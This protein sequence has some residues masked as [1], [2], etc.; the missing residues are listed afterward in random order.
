MR[1]QWIA[2]AIALA[3]CLLCFKFW[4]LQIVE[5]HEYA[6]LARDN[7]VWEKRLPSDRGMIYG[8]DG[9]VMADNRASADIVFVP[10]ECTEE[11]LPGVIEKISKL[12]NVP[13][14]AI[15]SR[16]EAA[17]GAPFS[18]VFIKRDVTRAD[19]IRVEEHSAALPGVL[20]VV[21][22]QRR[23]LHG[24]VGGQ[25]LGFLGQI[26]Q[27]ELESLK[28]EDYGQG[29]IVGKGGIERVYETDLRGHD[30]Y[31]VVTKYATGRPQLET[32]RRG[33][34][35]VSSRDSE[36]HLLR[37]EGARQSP[38]PGEPIYLTLDVDLQRHCEETLNGQVGSIV[39]LNADTGAIYAL[40]SNPSF[41]PNV[42]VTRDP[43]CENPETLDNCA[44]LALLKAPEPNP[45][46]SRAYREN[47]PPGSVYKVLLAAAALEEGV[48]DEHTS[49]YCPGHFQLGAG[50]HRWH[51]WRRTGHGTVAVR[52]ALAFSCDVFFYNVGLKLG[53][54]RIVSWSNKL[55]L[56]VKTGIDL[57]GEITGLIPS[58]D[59]KAKLFEGKAPSEKKW[60]DG[61]TVNLSIGQGSASATPL[62]NAVMMASI[63]NG[64]KR[65]RPYLNEALGPEISEPL[66]SDGHIQIIEE[67]MRMC[68][69]KK[70]PPPTG[71][72]KEAAVDGIVVIGKTG[73]AQIM[74]LKHHEKF[75]TEEDIPYEFRDHA[76]FVAGVLDQEPRIAMCILVE[77]GHHGS[78][79][80]APLA[81][82]V[83]EYFY[84]GV[85]SNPATPQVVAQAP[86]PPATEA[87]VKPLP[88][89]DDVAA[90]ETEMEL[91]P[92]ATPE[93]ET[94][95]APRAP[96]ATD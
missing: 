9:V 52:E 75:A 76:W 28:L 45:M 72:G 64:G 65:V 33:I 81:K 14:E 94:E 36:G 22:P 95:P 3:M 89:P 54:N 55:G 30:G 31:A 77:H 53:V 86:A 38:V 43:N 82:G 59:W 93:P 29:D 96:L 80:A 44:R 17:K 15:H 85:T 57:P 27:S 51:C 56:G 92:E 46:F 7:Q 42:F 4:Q 84:R 6:E 20:T 32:D 60:Y 8:R 83:I 47:Y 10:G 70:A 5:M 78:S 40:A 39:V 48:I 58:P 24:E 67:G 34:P 73:S 23:Y 91:A 90:L 49:Y 71:T 68:V 16:V 63:V 37:E 21:R 88:E 25:V 13:A 87:P 61:D 79:A 19:R 69:E 1:V 74:S 35:K 2:V 18:Q 26:S 66:I 11:E 41:D 12:V 62:Q 50:G